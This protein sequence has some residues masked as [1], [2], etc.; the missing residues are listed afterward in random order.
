MLL[1][2]SPCCLFLLQL[3]NCYSCP[4]SFH[5]GSSSC[6]SK[7]RG[8]YPPLQGYCSSR[9]RP[10]DQPVPGAR[11]KFTRRSQ[12]CKRRVGWMVINVTGRQKKVG[13]KIAPK[14]PANNKTLWVR[15]PE[16]KREGRRERERE[17]EKLKEKKRWSKRDESS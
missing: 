12:D 13:S 6:Y 15:N 17:R 11:A 7:N 2:L 3:F 4:H 10:R 9:H 1:S 14:T 8:Q 16:G 5:R